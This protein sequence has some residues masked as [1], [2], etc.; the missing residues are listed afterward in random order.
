[1]S[2]TP[3]SLKRRLLI[4]LLATTVVAWL[5]TLIL[6]YADT[7]H[8]L[9]EVL[10]AHLAQ[11]A[12][13]LVAQA[14]HDLE[15]ID[16]E[17]TTSAHRYSR[18][19]AFQIW[20]HGELRLR[21]A[22]APDQPLAPNDAGFADTTLSGTR[23]RVFSTQDERHDVLI[24][25]AESREV[26]DRLAGTIAEHLLQPLLITLPVL[27]VLIW[28]VVARGLRPLDRL[29][30]EVATRAP[31]NLAPLQTQ[32]APAEVAPLIDNLNR[33]FARVRASLDAE[34]RFTADA[35]HE[36]RTPLAAIRTQAQVA[37]AAGDAERQH[38]LKN[39]LTG[40][41]RATHVV[42]QMLTLARLE[43]DQL[44]HQHAPCDLRA[45][46]AEVVAE[47]A[48]AA[49]GKQV[50]LHL[51]ESGGV[52]AVCDAGLMRIVLRNL[53]DNGVRYSPAGS[54]VRVAVETLDDAAQISVTDQGPGIPAEARERLGERFYRVLG[55]GE[56]G[57][58][59]GL[60]I[61]KRIAELHG[62]TLQVSDNPDHQGLQV[63]LRL[64]RGGG[65]AKGV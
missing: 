14:G 45:L 34:R 38:A 60:S 26:R 22:G 32:D 9:E 8:E 25:V 58:G 40:C 39:V 15:E 20:V 56:S 42:E 59:L 44:R 65:P 49:I 16:T 6:S 13:L 29:R 57:S 23:W 46:A 52:E 50:E 31:G 1:M 18:H 43:P 30:D 11:S 48:P 24:Q 7:R 12:A 41:D 51:T 4:G 55:S 27:A 3:V 47:L 33:L 2:K 10:D 36:L 28:L 17:H 35:A 64:P 63:T 61:V 53:I 19:V 37:L 54:E 21:S 62:A 5:A